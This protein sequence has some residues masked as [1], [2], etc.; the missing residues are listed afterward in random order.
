MAG[1]PDCESASS[2]LLSGAGGSGQS[3]PFRTQTPF[4]RPDSVTSAV[5][6]PF[7]NPMKEWSPQDSLRVSGWGWV[8]H[9]MARA[10]S[11]WK[12]GVMF[13]LPQVKPGPGRAALWGLRSPTPPPEPRGHSPQPPGCL[14]AAPSEGPETHPRLHVVTVKYRQQQGGPVHR[15]LPS[16]LGHLRGE[17]DLLGSPQAQLQSQPVREAHG[18]PEGPCVSKP[19]GWYCSKPNTHLVLHV[20]WLQCRLHLQFFTKFL[21][22]SEGTDGGRNGTLKLGRRMSGLTQMKLRTLN[23]QVL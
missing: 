12:H 19:Q 10:G 18:G 9:Q 14:P 8:T 7:Q 22:K 3:R 5:L 4:S 2:A 15:T 6:L 20:A 1:A 21:M 17:K 16:V 23:P 11:C 13:R